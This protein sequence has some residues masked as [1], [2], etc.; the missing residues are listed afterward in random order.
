MR[1]AGA[2]A[3]AAVCVGTLVGC[4]SPTSDLP[5]LT[6]SPTISASPTPTPTPTPASAGPRDLSDPAL[7]IIF[8]DFPHDQDEQTAA[9][10]ETYMLFETKFWRALTT[11]VVAPGPWA[12][13]SDDSIA[14]IQ[15]QVGPNSENGWTT[16]GT[17]RTSVQVV[18]AA[19]GTT[20]LAVCTN[21]LEVTFK[22]VD[23][24]TTTAVDGGL[25]ATSGTLISMSNAFSTGWKVVGHEITGTC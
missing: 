8:T 11:N 15:A 4:S 21:W 24:T 17:Y 5:G 14:W 7:G 23:G 22:N 2:I 13:A 1:R 16:S 10:I 12:I 6:A 3:V 20:V 18:S 9:A 25:D 19:E